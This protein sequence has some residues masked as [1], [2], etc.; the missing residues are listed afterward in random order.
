MKKT[1]HNALPNTLSIHPLN[2]P[3]QPTHSTHNINTAIN[4]S[5][6][7]HTLTPSN[8]SINTPHQH[9][10]H[11]HPSNDSPSRRHRHHLRTIFHGLSAIPPTRSRVVFLVT[12]LR[13]YHSVCGASY[14]HARGSGS[15]GTILERRFCGQTQPGETRR[16]ADTLS[17][18]MPPYPQIPMPTSLFT[19]TTT[20]MATY[21]QRILTAY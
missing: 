19:Y 18:T 5:P 10:H 2:T 3:T 9:L 17:S 1:M 21:Q 12:G 13:V 11:R 7:Q 20:H 14:V 8:T 15:H 6:Y 4:A 16:D